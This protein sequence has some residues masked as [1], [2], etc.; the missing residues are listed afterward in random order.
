[1]HWPVWGLNTCCLGLLGCFSCFSCFV[2]F[3]V[4]SFL[5]VVIGAAETDPDP[6]R[7]VAAIVVALAELGVVVNSKGRTFTA[8]PELE[9]E[10][11]HSDE[12]FPFWIEVLWIGLEPGRAAWTSVGLIIVDLAVTFALRSCRTL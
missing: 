2:S 8:P 11:V 7:H 6:S 9:F 10:H 3:L 1:M 5:F 12:D 4:F